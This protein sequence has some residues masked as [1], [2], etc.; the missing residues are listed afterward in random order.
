MNPSLGRVIRSRLALTLAFVFVFTVALATQALTTQALAAWP[1]AASTETGVDPWSRFPSTQASVVTFQAPLPAA[2]GSH[3]AA[4]DSL[5][6]LRM[7]HIGGPADPSDADAVLT[8]MPGILEG[9][10]AFEN[11]GRNLITRARNERGKF[12]EVWAIDRRANCLEDLG[13][14]AKARATHSAQ[15]LLDYYYDGASHEGDTFDGFRPSSELGWVAEMGLDQTLRDWNEVIVR[16]IPSQPLRKQKLYCG[17]HSLGGILTGEYLTWDADGNAATTTDA[18]YNQCA[19]TFALD[20]F[21]TAD[22][23]KIGQLT[24]LTGTGFLP[25]GVNDL[26]VDLLRNNTIP[27]AVDVPG[28]NPEVMYFLTGIG[29]MADDAPAAENTLLTSAPE[30]DKIRMAQKLFFSRNYTNFLTQ[31]P[32]IRDFR[33][34]NRA[35]LGTFMDD[36]SFPLSFVQASAGFY[37]GGSVATKNFPTP[38][39]LVQLPL[40]GPLLDYMVG[41]GDLAIPTNYGWWPGTRTGPVYDWLDYNEVT[42]TNIPR[43]SVFG[44]RYT[45]PSREVTDI[46]DL[47]HGVAGY[48][49]NFVEAYYPTRMILDASFG[50]FGSHAASPNLLHPNGINQVSK[51]DIAGGEGVVKLLMPIVNPQAKVVEG[52]NHID[53]LTAAPVQNNGQP[54][55]VT[56]H[57]L[58]YVF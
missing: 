32:D 49:V 54:E 18:G 57:L 14:L 40:I 8:M 22:P 51:L 5:K 47:A 23:V 2:A 4:C 44:P 56:T 41:G 10:S 31:Y 26:A 35:L 58:D 36:N 48:P 9:A 15:D 38:D 46:N 33:F 17:G 1:P 50:L 45:S 7:R 21:V 19:G 3:P 11:V 37:K 39:I 20:S 30:T 6:I 16:G 13:G 25:D 29:F 55:P 24:A 42:T 43:K 34:T 53:V 12:I 28:I 27:R 52:Y